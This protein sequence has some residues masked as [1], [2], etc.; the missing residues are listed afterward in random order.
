MT[1]KIR[2][3]LPIFLLLTLVFVQIGESVW[4]NLPKS[5]NKCVSE[6]IHNNVVVVGDY[7]VISDDHL[8]PTPTISSKCGVVWGKLNN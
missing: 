3:L 6:E 5:G 1:D 4:L 8:H 7:V 2:L